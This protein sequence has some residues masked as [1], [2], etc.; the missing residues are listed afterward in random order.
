MTQQLEPVDT[1]S[2]EV[3]SWKHLLGNP[4]LKDL[5]PTML[6]PGGLVETA[7]VRIQG[8]SKSADKQPIPIRYDKSFVARKIAK[9]VIT[10]IK[11]ESFEALVELIKEAWSYY[12]VLL[13]EENAKV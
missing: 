13:E 10:K 12:E 4:Y 9:S 7:L 3:K 11:P 8:M 1:K 2:Q 5:H 6:L